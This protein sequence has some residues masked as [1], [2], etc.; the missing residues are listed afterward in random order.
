[1]PHGDGE[2]LPDIEG[3]LPESFHNGPT[4][5]EHGGGNPQRGGSV[6]RRTW[7]GFSAT[8]PAQPHRAHPRTAPGLE[9]QASGL[10]GGRGSTCLSPKESEWGTPAL[11]PAFSP[12]EKV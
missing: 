10:A 8:P 11:I 3:A 5:A 4:H 1:M 7:S 2:S 6:N 9:A 12:E